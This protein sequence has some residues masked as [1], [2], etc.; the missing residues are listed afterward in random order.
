ML[1][2]KKPTMIWHFLFV[3]FL[4]VRLMISNLIIFAF[5]LREHNMMMTM[6]YFTCLKTPLST[7][8][9][10]V[11]GQKVIFNFIIFFDDAVIGKQK[12]MPGRIFLFECKHL[13]L[14]LFSTWL[15]V[16]QKIIKLVLFLTISSF[17]Q[18]SIV[19]ATS[20]SVYYLL[21][22]KMANLPLSNCNMQN[23]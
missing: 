6:K 18:K 1:Q 20:P 13:Y 19:I 5:R 16:V 7:Q 4:L 10:R 15:V 14:P 9:C 3:N 11:W 12:I 23:S 2:L 21:I 17:L 8:G 22:C